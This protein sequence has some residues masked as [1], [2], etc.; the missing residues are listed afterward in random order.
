[1]ALKNKGENIQKFISGGK[2]DPVTDEEIQEVINQLQAD[3]ITLK[4]IE[5]I[6]G[7]KISKEEFQRIELSLNKRKTNRP[8]V[9]WTKEKDKIIHF[10]SKCME[11]IMKK[12]NQSSQKMSQLVH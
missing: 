7:E 6:I 12:S 8:I 9:K 5:N 1:M 4:K 10:F 11:E 2:L 3:G